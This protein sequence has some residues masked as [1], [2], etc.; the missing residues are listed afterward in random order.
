M[1]KLFGFK[2]QDTTGAD[3]SKSIIS[4]VPPNEEDKS[5]FYSKHQSYQL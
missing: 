1:A 2:I 3:K 4:P 5:D